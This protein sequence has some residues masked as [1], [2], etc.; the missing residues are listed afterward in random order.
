ML[1]YSPIISKENRN[2]NE[3]HEY[4]CRILKIIYD[5][6]KNYHYI[7]IEYEKNGVIYLENV[8][9]EEVLEIDDDEYVGNMKC[10]NQ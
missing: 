8:M 5:E 10:S 7:M 4:K 3:I 9:C 2:N 1:I 6:Y